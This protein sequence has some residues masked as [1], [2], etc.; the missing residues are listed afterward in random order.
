MPETIQ[1]E[2]TYASPSKRPREIFEPPQS[3][4]H[5]R[6][7]SDRNSLTTS[8]ETIVKYDACP[9]PSVVD[10]FYE[11]LIPKA[12]ELSQLF[13]NLCHD[14]YV[15]RRWLGS[16]GCAIY[17]RLVMEEIE[18]SADVPNLSHHL[19]GLIARSLT[20]LRGP[21]NEA[22]NPKFHTLCEVLRLHFRNDDASKVVVFGESQYF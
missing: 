17:W 3:P 19:A 18:G 4:P 5:K 10:Y 22:S 6:F 15:V 16:V 21:Q 9:T 1:Q 12:S 11:D 20:K 13:P 8:A 2:V 14:A 7:K